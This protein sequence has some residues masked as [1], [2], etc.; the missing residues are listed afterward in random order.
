MQNMMI[1]LLLNQLKVKNPQGY[2][3]VQSLMNSGKDPEQILNELVQTGQF[4]QSQ[5]QQAN[6]IAS[7]YV[8]NSNNQGSNNIKRF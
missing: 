8:Q 7:Q 5:I 3:T 4:T 6:K 1:N 2:N